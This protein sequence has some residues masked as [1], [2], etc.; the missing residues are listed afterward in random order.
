MEAKRRDGNYRIS[1]SAYEIKEL[2]EGRKTCSILTDEVNGVCMNFGL[3]KM[4]NR[5]CRLRGDDNWGKILFVSS[6][7]LSYLSAQL[8]HAPMPTTSFSYDA[9]TE[10][11]LVTLCVK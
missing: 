9:S 3:Q 10:A 11:G 5:G 8:T 4:E 1:L 7:L 6:E 2:T